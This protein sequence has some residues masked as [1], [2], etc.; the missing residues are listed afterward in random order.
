[1]SIAPNP[2]AP[3]H[4]EEEKLPRWL[5]ALLAAC[6]GAMLLGAGFL[7]FTRGT[8]IVLDIAAVFCL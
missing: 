8:A 6:F 7:W 4:D 3:D 1:M 2:I 5:V